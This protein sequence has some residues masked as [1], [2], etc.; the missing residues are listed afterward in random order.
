[1]DD[2]FFKHAMYMASNFVDRKAGDMVHKL[3]L[4]GDNYN[5]ILS[6]ATVWLL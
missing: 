3:L 5:F 6:A 2:K 1:M 4:T